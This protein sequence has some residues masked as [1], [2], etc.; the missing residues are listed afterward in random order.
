[1]AAVA[2]LVTGR[3]VGFFEAVTGSVRPTG[4]LP[5]T[6]LSEDF[7]VSRAGLTPDFLDGE[8]PMAKTKT[9]MMLKQITTDLKTKTF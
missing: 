6:G 9:L 4:D 3:D 8:Q 7:E 2:G 5:E 1:M